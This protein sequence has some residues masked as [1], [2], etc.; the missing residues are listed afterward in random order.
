ME[1]ADTQGITVAV[2]VR[3]LPERSNPREKVYLFGYRILIENG[4]PHPVQLLRRHWFITDAIAQVREV[5]GEGVVGQQ[6]ILLP[7]ESFQYDS[8]CDLRTEIG[9]MSGTY[10]MS[11]LDEDIYFYVTIPE[12]KMAADCI[13]N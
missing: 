1:V 2:V 8:F 5:E 4:S 13:L 12:F 10:L 6:P 3:Y 7:G 9:K 11:R